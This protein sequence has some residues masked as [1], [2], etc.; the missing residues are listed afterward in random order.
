M[1]THDAVQADTRLI[2][3]EARMEAAT[4]ALTIACI[5]IERIEK[6]A[7]ERGDRRPC[8]LVQVG[9]YTCGD[10]EISRRARYSPTVAA[11]LSLNRLP[12]R[13]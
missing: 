6:R 10:S 4:G 11:A 2:A 3:L 8:L 9:Q 12:E 7:T 13:M 5:E 1:K